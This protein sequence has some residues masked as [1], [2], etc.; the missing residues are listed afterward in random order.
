MLEAPQLN[1][2]SYELMMERARSLI[3]TL[4]G[5]WTDLNHHDPG[6]TTL[7]TFAW[8]CDML[9]Y[10]MG[11]VGPEH[12]RKYMALLGLFPRRERAASC[13]VA[14][15]RQGGEPAYL[16][17]GTRLSAEGLVFETARGLWVGEN[18]LAVLARQEGDAFDDLTGVAGVDGQ[19]VPLFRCEGSALYL[20]W[21]G[22]LS[23]PVSLFLEC[24]TPGERNPFDDDFSL[25]TLCWEFY[26]GDGW[27][28]AKVLKD[29][30]CGF[31]R[32]GL[33]ELELEAATAPGVPLGGLESC[34]S[35]RCRLLESRYELPPRLGRVELN[36]VRVRQTDTAAHLQVLAWEGDDLLLDRHIPDLAV[37]T[38]ALEENDCFEVWYRGNPAEGD[39]N[40]L[41][42]LIRD[43]R[44]LWRIRFSRGKHG[45]APAA[46]QRI[47]V[48]I[49]HGPLA[50]NPVIGVTTGFSSQRIKLD[51]PEEPL[52]LQLG[53][54]L[55]EDGGRR[56]I[57]LW[58]RCED[59]RL[60]G[61]DDEAFSYRPESGELV[62][63]DSIH[64]LL[65]P[66]GMEILL[67]GLQT[68]RLGGGNILK[69]ELA[70]VEGRED[71]GAENLLDAVDGRER[72]SDRE[73]EDRLP[74][75]LTAVGRAVCPEDYRAAV[76]AVPGL[77]IDRVSVIPG[78]KY[79]EL[80]D[81]EHLPGSVYV[82]VKP[83]LPG[84]PRL[85]AHYRSR[86]EAHLESYRLLATRIVV[87][88]AQYVG[89]EVGGRIVLQEGPGAGAEVRELL[90]SLVE[91]DGSFGRAIAYGSLYSALEMCPRVRKVTSLTLSWRGWGGRKTRRGDI[92][93]F[94]DCIPYLADVQID[95]I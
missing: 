94:P 60:A 41:C 86:I 39:E 91:G 7:Q 29:E 20:G 43:E 77:M 56:R 42:R 17:A 8:L 63:G 75:H 58:R 33:V 71:V 35:L 2:L 88:P 28:A 74:K 69:G 3:P 21:E 51:L 12:R 50:L 11:A 85:S 32:S 81:L 46:G 22:A 27:R 87:L 57:R 89:I 45:R 67:L 31:L 84:R 92:E 68:S 38:V 30:T 80:Y 16:P 49:A 19:T 83:A 25:A 78:S 54:S 76:K 65:P 34:H 48:S 4:T 61:P 82:A 37:V 79:A 53:L 44:G 40:A 5:E 15:Y 52:E 18:R 90:R 59:I 73:L 23:G 55:P 26:D 66:A 6:I 70:R 13:P 10:Y 36:G 14:L 64:G 62:F 24:P 72:E 1:D 9:G 47:L 95:F 93:V